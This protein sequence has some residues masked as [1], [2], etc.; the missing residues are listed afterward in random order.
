MGRIF[1]LFFFLIIHIDWGDEQGELDEYDD[2]K[3]VIGDYDDVEKTAQQIDLHK[4]YVKQ[5][6]Q[7]NNEDGSESLIHRNDN[8]EGNNITIPANILGDFMPLLNVPFTLEP[9]DT[10][11]ESI[12]VILL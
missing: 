10:G 11:P 6:L 8:E 2:E 1:F 3:D 9:E 5:Q 4:E 7:K 12:L